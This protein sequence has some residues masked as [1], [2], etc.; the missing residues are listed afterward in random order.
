MKQI[1][2]ILSTV[3][4]FSCNK[5]DNGNSGNNNPNNNLNS[6]EQK[7]L[8]TWYL[9]KEADTT[10]IWGDLDTIQTKT[11]TS[12]PSKLYITFKSTSN[13]NGV[14]CGPQGKDFEDFCG[15]S[16]PNINGYARSIGAITTVMQLC[17]YFNTTNNRLT[18]AGGSPEIISISNNA[19]VLRIN[20]IDDPM[21]QQK[22]Y[23]TLY[24]EK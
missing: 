11:Y 5:S 1:L 21:S 15:M 19:L 13:V 9:K 17:W 14:Q 4:L 10:I 22:V 6:T 16:L 12:F 18:L 8:G 2:I 20:Y 3:M 23:Y 7:I 24:F